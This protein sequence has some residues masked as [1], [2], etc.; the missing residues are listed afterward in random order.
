M[1][2]CKEEHREWEADENTKVNSYTKD[3]YNHMKSAYDTYG[4]MLYPRVNVEK[5]RQYLRSQFRQVQQ[6]ALSAG[7]GNV[8]PRITYS[9][10]SFE[11]PGSN[12]HIPQAYNHTKG[13]GPPQPQLLELDDNVLDAM[14]KVMGMA[15]KSKQIAKEEEKV[16]KIYRCQK[17]GCARTY[18]TYARYAKHL[19]LFHAPKVVVKTE[20]P[21]AI[22]EEIP[23]TH[24]AN[25]TLTTSVSSENEGERQI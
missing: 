2:N 12:P 24:N 14:L 10:R 17:P 9:H 15:R 7:I 4:L 22:Q 21:T 11:I 3:N 8:V 16:D 20:V 23:M 6:Q 19:Q 18:A 25:G 1:E 5:K 13:C